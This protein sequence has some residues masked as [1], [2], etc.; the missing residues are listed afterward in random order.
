MHPEPNHGVDEEWMDHGVREVST[1]D[2]ILLDTREVDLEQ[3]Q[4]Q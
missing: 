1:Q 3:P 2:S 4:S